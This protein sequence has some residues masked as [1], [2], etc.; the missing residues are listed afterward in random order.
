[1]LLISTV[2]ASVC[3]LKLTTD[4]HTVVIIVL[5]GVGRWCAPVDRKRNTHAHTCARLGSENVGL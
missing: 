4:C 2:V 3:A 1:M 5:A